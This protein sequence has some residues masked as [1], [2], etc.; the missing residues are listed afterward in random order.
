MVLASTFSLLSFHPLRA[1]IVE[2]AGL[3]GWRTLHDL[4]AAGTEGGRVPADLASAIGLPAEPPNVDELS[5]ALRQLFAILASVRPLIVVLD[6]LHWA[7]P[8]FLTIVD[9]LGDVLAEPVL[10][11]CLARS[12]ELPPT[13]LT[14]D[15]LDLAPLSREEIELLV[16]DR[17]GSVAPDVLRRTVELAQGNPLFAE[18][19]LAAGIEGATGE[20]PT[21]LL[22]LLNMRLDRLGPGERDLLRCASIIGVDFDE[23]TLGIL[24]PEEA[25]PFM[26]RHLDTLARRQ[27][28]DR[29]GT[30]SFR[31]RHP[32]IQ[33]TAYRTTTRADRER[34]RAALA[35]GL[36]QTASRPSPSW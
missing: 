36:R 33:L 14:P 26:P 32:L 16:Q 15:P 35:A 25:R 20:V 34:L 1:A 4:L 11:L 10:L 19:L 21:S 23:E 18:Q 31:F 17:V 24:M 6:D 12:E 22:G 27:M 28:I 2:A 9:N 7:S 29:G 30:Q 3:T 8:A 13:W 5:A